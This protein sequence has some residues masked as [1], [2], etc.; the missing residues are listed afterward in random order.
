MPCA[1]QLN[2][3]LGDRL[4]APS[5]LRAIRTRRSD[6]ARRRFA[7]RLD[8][9][10][11]E[12]CAAL[13]PGQP[14]RVSRS[15]A[16]A[17]LQ[18]VR[19]L[20]AL[21]RAGGQDARG[22]VERE[23][24][25]A[26]GAVAIAIR[27]G[28]ADPVATAYTL[29]PAL[30]SRLTHEMRATFGGWPGFVVPTAV[31]EIAALIG[32]VVDALTIMVLDRVTRGVTG[33]YERRIEDLEHTNQHLQQVAIRDGKTG[34]LNYD[35]F[36]ERLQQELDRA[37][38]YDMPLALV[39]SDLDGFKAYNDAH[40]HLY[41]DRV[42]ALVAA[43]ITQSARSSDMVGRYGGEEFAILLPHT[44]L[45]GGVVRAERVRQAVEHAA[46]PSRD[47]GTAR[48]TIT[49]GVAAYP[50]HGATMDALL[51]AADAAMYVAKRMGK[52]AVAAAGE[53]T[54]RSGVAESE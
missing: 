42:L 37:G 22:A 25:V 33:E 35:T 31:G 5:I 54:V 29:G 3:C 49:L 24:E 19:L 38:R 16:D 21:L 20:G 18:L 4:I 2:G 8:A 27:S 41:G 30:R 43:L 23:L 46:F 53:S 52:N 32:E 34:L 36:R 45:E 15:V 11:P 28:H 1:S 6:A 47:G 10:A 48:L 44:D 7:D 26:A 51:D 9:V 39:M 40:G 12:S 50:T 13:L 17:C 14:E